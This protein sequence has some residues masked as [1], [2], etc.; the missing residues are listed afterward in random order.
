MKDLQKA[1]EEIIKV[2]LGEYPVD[3]VGLSTGALA[4]RIA[5]ST[6]L[7]TSREQEIREEATGVLTQGNQ[8]GG[9]AESG[10]TVFRTPS[11]KKLIPV[12]A[13]QSYN[14]FVEWLDAMGWLR[15]FPLGQETAIFEWFYTKNLTQKENK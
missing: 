5:E 13:Q 7:I 14:D 1:I 3:Q 10:D 15:E 6:Q 2:Y 8:S 11:S 4:G 9:V 12:Q